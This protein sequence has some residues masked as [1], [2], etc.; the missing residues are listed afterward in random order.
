MRASIDRRTVVRGIGAALCSVAA[1]GCAGPDRPGLD[2][3][4][5]T[6]IT[7][8]DR[9]EGDLAIAA[10][11]NSLENLAI[12]TYV[13]A[14]ERVARGDVGELP[15]AVAAHIDL[16]QAHH[17]DHARAW[18]GL[19]TGAGRPGVTG[20][21]LTLKTRL[22]PMLLRAR[23]YVGL[24]T[25]FSELESITAATYLAGI[26]AMTNNAA[27]KIAA[28]IHPVELQH[29]SFLNLV[30]DRPPLPDSFAKAD[31]ARPTTDTVG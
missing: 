8:L 3:D 9:L 17:E 7:R 30:L 18:N 12:A 25:V 16:A 11:A 31:G 1:V 5:V 28:S 22:E 20:V 14:R 19:I 10:L 24:A 4:D 23:D 15:P 21:N 13:A 2:G 26:E 6:G 29:A 27:V